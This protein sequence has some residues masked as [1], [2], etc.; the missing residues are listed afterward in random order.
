MKR[1]TK[2]LLGVLGGAAAVGGGYLLYRRSG[3]VSDDD[4]TPGVI[5]DDAPFSDD[6]PTGNDIGISAAFVP[7]PPSPP[8]P[9]MAS[10][11][12]N[13]GGGSGTLKIRTKPAKYRINYTQSH[14]NGS[15]LA[16]LFKN[17]EIIEHNAGQN[18]QK[19]WNVP[20]TAYSKDYPFAYNVL[21]SPWADSLA[22]LEWPEFLAMPKPSGIAIDFNPQDKAYVNY[23]DKWVTKSLPSGKYNLFTDA[24]GSST[25][26]FQW[27]TGLWKMTKY[28]PTEYSENKIKSAVK[29]G[30]NCHSTETKS[31]LT[32]QVDPRGDIR[33]I[34]ITNGGTTQI[35]MQPII[36]LNIHNRTYVQTALGDV[37]YASCKV[38]GVLDWIGD[39]FS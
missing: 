1:N 5:P 34:Q 3:D 10:L 28:G 25:Y 17:N 33:T 21:A 22:L 39:L 16:K 9:S 20:G 2:I 18:L 31:K 23:T 26:K 29:K 19:G 6:P 7:P 24:W 30:K 12:P 4:L 11:M 36:N 14:W 27:P 35:T 8:G 13:L 37:I 38:G 15:N 32:V